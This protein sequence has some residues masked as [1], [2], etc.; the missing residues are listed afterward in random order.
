VQNHKT[1]SF[2]KEIYIHSDCLNSEEDTIFQI[3][4]EIFHCLMPH[5][6]VSPTFFEEGMATYF[7]IYILK[8][9]NYN[10]SNLNNPNNKY[11]QALD[12]VTRTKTYE[13]NI[14][15]KVRSIESHLSCAKK[16]TILKFIN[17]GE[18]DL[19]LLLKDFY[20]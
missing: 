12:L 19:N 15:K 11:F 13:S 18:E 6:N 14:I 3:S 17:I 7:S 20:K 4:H 8:Y 10:T 1:L 5:G 16:E 2:N 9:F